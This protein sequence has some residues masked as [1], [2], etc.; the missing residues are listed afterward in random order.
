MDLISDKGSV[1]GIDT[2]KLALRHK[3]VKY[4][5]SVSLIGRKVSTVHKNTIFL[6]FYE[7]L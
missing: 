4:V 2:N 7:G 1:R 5:S 6:S 3:V